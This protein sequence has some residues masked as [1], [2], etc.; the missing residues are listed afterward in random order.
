MSPIPRSSKWHTAN[1]PQ[2]MARAAPRVVSPLASAHNDA[3]WAEWYRRFR[4]RSRSQSRSQSRSRSRSRSNSRSSSRSRSQSPQPGPSGWTAATSRANRSNSNSSLDRNTRDEL[5]DYADRDAETNHTNNPNINTNDGGG[6]QTELAKTHC[7]TEPTVDQG[8]DRNCST[9]RT[10]GTTVTAAPRASLGD[11]DRDIGNDQRVCTK[12]HR[13]AA[14]EKLEPTEPTE[15]AEPTEPDEPDEPAEPAALK[16]TQLSQTLPTSQ[17]SQDTQASKTLISSKE[18][19][20]HLAVQGAILGTITRGNI[21]GE[22][23]GEISG[24]IKSGP[25]KKLKREIQLYGRSS[26]L[27]VEE[28]RVAKRDPSPT[29]AGTETKLS[30]KRCVSNKNREFGF[31]FGI[32]GWKALLQ[33]K[34]KM[35]W[36]FRRTSSR[37]EET[38][39]ISGKTDEILQSILAMQAAQKQQAIEER[40]D[41]IVIE[42]LDEN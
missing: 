27:P 40:D 22:I 1:R 10:L 24:E 15:P 26:S 14:G 29:N 30:R 17:T 12:T 16:E 8:S 3:Q 4:S 25:I 9:T 42:P 33:G 5:L 28:T 11:G 41:G 36:T 13:G 23:T 38:N 37:I 18:T 19:P 6:P 21:T 20:K 35:N 39:E 34:I 32:D 2:R 7:V 31:D